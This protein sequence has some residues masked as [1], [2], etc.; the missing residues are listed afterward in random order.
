MFYVKLALNNLRQSF[1]NFAP[2]FLVSVTTFVF[3][4]ITLLIMQSPTSKTMGLGVMALGL[5]YIVLSILSAILCLYSYNF[6][7]KQRNQEFGLYNILGMNKRQITGLSTI[8]L[9]ISYLITVVLGSLL[10]AVFSNFFYIIFVNLINYDDLNFK[11]SPSAFVITSALFAVIFLVLEIVNFS[12][13]TK[14][15]LTKDIKDEVVLFL[16]L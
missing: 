5:A 9:G 10:S 15:I 16:N 6:L 3:S 12:A 4:N 2:F 11:L 1:K 13:K 7:L 14:K 8:E